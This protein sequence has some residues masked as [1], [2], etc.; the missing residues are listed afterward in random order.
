LISAAPWIDEQVF[1]LQSEVVER[2]TAAAGD[3]EYSRLSVML[4][5]RYYVEQIMNVP[6]EAFEPKP[7]VNSAVVRMI[8]RR[9]FDLTAKEWD[10]LSKIVAMAFAQRRKMLRSNLHAFQ[11][12]L[13]LSDEELKARAQEITV[14]RYIEW[15]KVLTRSS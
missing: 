15:A 4:Q 3:S 10:A 2:I 11:S 8:P 6:P 7:K 9:D 12:E 13:N 1:M 14:G 5:A